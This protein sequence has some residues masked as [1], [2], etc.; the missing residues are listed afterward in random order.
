[1][2]A[3]PKAVALKY[4]ADKDRA[5][6]VTAKGSGP[7]AEKIVAIA[8]AHD[9]PLHQDRNLVELLDALEIDTQIPPELYRAVAEVLAF[10][11]RLNRESI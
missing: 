11:Y 3:H 5:P 9:I 8:K 6:R 2:D 10:I 4:R 7:L 1:M